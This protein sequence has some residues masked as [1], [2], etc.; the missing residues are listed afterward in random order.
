MKP[1][2][3]VASLMKL[4]V[5]YVFTHD[6][7][8]VGEDGPTHQPVEQLANL[9]SIPG[10][11]VIRPADATET[12]AAWRQAVRTTSGP[13]ALV[14]SRQKL[15]VL[16]QKKSADELSNGAYVLADSNGKPDIILIATGS[17]V[18]IALEAREQLAQKGIGAR[19]VSMPSWEL[20]EKSSQAYKDRVLLPGVAARIAIEAGL[21][22]GWERYAGSSGTIIGM[23]GFGASAPGNVVMEKSGFTSENIV[24]KA[25]DL[26][27]K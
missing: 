14:L 12:A 15:P 16:G 26:L 11:T 21:P 9:R 18:H 20:F 8:A 10:I 13:V 5:I 6:S 17:E 7:I 3:R 23:T 1:A 24:Q 4:P 19:V 27:S 2:I 22:M 25:L